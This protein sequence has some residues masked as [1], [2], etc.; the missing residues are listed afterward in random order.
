[1]FK[2][3]TPNNHN[4]VLLQKPLLGMDER[5]NTAHATKCSQKNRHLLGNERSQRRKAQVVQKLRAGDGGHAPELTYVSKKYLN[6]ILRFLIYEHLLLNCF[7][8]VQAQRGARSG[9]GKMCLEKVQWGHRIV[10]I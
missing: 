10:W 2:A 5:L 4:T 6:Q 1:M 9:P 8:Q 7:G 3:V